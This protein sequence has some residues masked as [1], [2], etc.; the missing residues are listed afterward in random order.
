[1]FKAKGPALSPAT[2]YTGALRETSFYKYGHLRSLGPGGELTALA[3]DPLLS[4]LAVGTS[5]GSIHVFGG[6][7]FQFTLPIT[8][9]GVRASVGGAGA[10][11]KFLVFHPGHNRLVAIDDNNT[12]HSFALGQISDAPNPNV[13]PPLPMREA[14]HPLFA[15]VTAVEQP[16]PSYTHMFLAMQDGTLLA[17]DLRQKGLSTYRVDNLWAVHEERLVRS[18]VPGAHKSIGG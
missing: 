11:V 7:S 10:G 14:L 4:L 5:S 17:W 12:I 3:V 13:E 1:M 6:Q 15:N 16:L 2:D 9:P 8:P 18:G